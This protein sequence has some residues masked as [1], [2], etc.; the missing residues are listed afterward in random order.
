MQI[1]NIS[2]KYIG[3]NMSPLVGIMVSTAIIL[4]SIAIATLII[5]QIISKLITNQQAK[6][7]NMETI[8]SHVSDILSRQE[9]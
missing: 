4:V 9:K 2:Y 5:K 6:N 7:S 3:V 1:S 8:Y